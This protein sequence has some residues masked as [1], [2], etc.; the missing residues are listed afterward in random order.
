M[1]WVNAMSEADAR[2][3]SR[4][5]DK[6]ALLLLETGR[7]GRALRNNASEELIAD[8]TVMMHYC[9]LTRTL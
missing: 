2:G 4:R 1:V 8:V 9:A 3:K 5:A 7:M 6:I